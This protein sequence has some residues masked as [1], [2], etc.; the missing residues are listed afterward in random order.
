MRKTLIIAFLAGLILFASFGCRK[1]AKSSERYPDSQLQRSSNKTQP[2]KP[3]RK[4][5]KLRL[6]NPR[7]MVHKA[8]RKLEL[9]SGE[10]LLRTYKIGLGFTPV[11]DK[12]KE[13]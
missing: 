2:S 9:Y 10:E 11:A 4:P 6:E 8:A 13:G 12:K 1:V 7:I 5:L 3:D